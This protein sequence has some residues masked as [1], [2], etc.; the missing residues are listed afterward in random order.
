MSHAWQRSGS[1]GRK[2]YI[3]LLLTR[4][5]RRRLHGDYSIT[6]NYPPKK[7]AT[8]LACLHMC[9]PFVWEQGKTR[10][11]LTV[12]AFNTKFPPGFMLILKSIS[13]QERHIQ[14]SSLASSRILHTINSPLWQSLSLLSF[15]SDARLCQ[16]L[17]S[18]EGKAAGS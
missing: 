9:H 4:S 16:P 1:I 5:K 17:V 8:F 10:S 7:E 11:T 3:I 2:L 13:G 14:D 15:R 6:L 12:K 18:R